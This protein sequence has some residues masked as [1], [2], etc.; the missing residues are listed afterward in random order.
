ATKSLKGTKERKE[1]MTVYVKSAHDVKKSETTNTKSETTTTKSE[2]YYDTW[3]ADVRVKIVTL[4]ASIV[5]ISLHDVESF[6]GGISSFK[7]N[8]KWLEEKIQNVKKTKLSLDAILRICLSISY[9]KFDHT[10]IYKKLE[11][12]CE[13]FPSD[14]PNQHIWYR[15]WR[16]QLW[17]QEKEKLE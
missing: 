14:D 12:L 1:Y 16:F 3:E 11:S 13:S 6:P 7:V 4:S 15:F 5:R 8:H 17:I 10:S 2:I 9:P